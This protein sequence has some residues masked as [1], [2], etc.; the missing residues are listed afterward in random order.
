MG[1]CACDGVSAGGVEV[2]AWG[3]EAG[4]GD[5]DGVTE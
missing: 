2:E 3:C 4:S 5:C 1:R